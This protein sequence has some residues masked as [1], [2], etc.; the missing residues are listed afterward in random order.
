M[1]LTCAGQSEFHQRGVVTFITAGRL[2]LK[3]R[4]RDPGFDFVGAIFGKYH[5]KSNGLGFCITSQ[6]NIQVCKKL[7]S[8]RH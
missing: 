7:A 1:R 2:P 3:M 5:L 8:S 4:S 6:N